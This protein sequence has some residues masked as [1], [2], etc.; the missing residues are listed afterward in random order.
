M[1]ITPVAVMR[2]QISIECSPKRGK[3]QFNLLQILK[4]M[5]TI[6]YFG[7]KTSTNKIKHFIHF[8]EFLLYHLPTYHLRLFCEEM[9]PK[10]YK[11]LSKQQGSVVSFQI[12]PTSRSLSLFMS[13]KALQYHPFL[14]H[15]LCVTP[16]RHR[17]HF[18]WF[19]KVGTLSICCWFSVWPDGQIIY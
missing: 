11:W 5:M 15:S 9:R 6:T 13:L 14:V 12:P 4:Y 8:S 10:P 2:C 7:C 3:D 18:V 17:A 1:T 19:I 16:H